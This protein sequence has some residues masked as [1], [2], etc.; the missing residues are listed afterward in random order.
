MIALP[1]ALV[2]QGRVSGTVYDSLR[3]GAPLAGARVVLDGV[4][5]TSVTDERGRFRLADVPPG[6]YLATFFHPWLDSIRTAAPVVEVEVRA[7]VT[8]TLFLATPT[9]RTL[10]AYLCGAPQDNA[11]AVVI[12]RAR[13]I[14]DGRPLEGALARVD[15]FEI[16]IGMIEGV[17]R[18]RRTLEA[19]ADADGEFVLCGVPNDVAI[20]MR[21]SAG[22][23][24]T[25]PVELVLENEPIAWREVAV[26]LT[27]TA[28]RLR[29]VGVAGDTASAVDPP[30]GSALLRVLVRD[31]SARPLAGALV[32]VRGSPVSGTTN[33]DGIVVLAGVPAGSQTLVVRSI[34]SSPTTQ[35][36][37]LA[38]SRETRIEITVR[39]SAVELAAVTVHG[40]RESPE[41]AAF[42]RR[43]RSGAGYF[44]DGD[45]LRRGGG[46]AVLATIPGLTMRQSSMGG[47]AM[48]QLRKASGASCEPDVLV[49]GIPRVR[50]DGW[51]L[52]QLMSQAVRVEVYTRRMLVPSEFVSFKEC[53]V[54]AIWSR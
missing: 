40:V 14:E 51:E 17:Q 33:A 43:R 16:T 12:G 46:S 8:T 23:Q 37:E 6:R 21:V 41:V 52:S 7:N 38:P 53:G 39:K 5:A 28:A 45:D 50:M 36:A 31:A 49:D 35:V 4:S 20:E 44:L 15:W 27:D 22:E 29:A 19:R 1:G 18:G 32:G 3:A 24:S 26:S 25:G 47:N 10:S 9:W 30:R 54:I 11:T 42:E 13:A 34:G 2:A 48:P